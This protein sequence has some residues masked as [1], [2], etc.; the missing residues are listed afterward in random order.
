MCQPKATI[1]SATRVASRSPPWIE[2]C[3]F[4]TKANPYVHR[5]QKLVT[6][7][8]AS[9]KMATES[10]N[11]KVHGR[12]AQMP[13]FSAPENFHR[14]V[15]V[16]RCKGKSAEHPLQPVCPAKKGL[17]PPPLGSSFPD[18][19]FLKIKQ[20][21]LLPPSLNGGGLLGSV[22]PFHLCP[23]FGLCDSWMLPHQLPPEL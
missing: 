21:F 17:S 1:Y 7:C 18:D 3:T 22:P 23:L 16:C 15:R 8:N 19:R 13:V 2:R 12:T 6:I 14:K 4:N 10:S 11:V 20:L 9:Q 5:K